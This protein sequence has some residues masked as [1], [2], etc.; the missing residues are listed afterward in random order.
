MAFGST[1]KKI[2]KVALPAAAGLGLTAI[3]GGAINPFTAKGLTGALSALGTLGGAAK[4]SATQAEAM[5]EEE[6]R[7]EEERKLRQQALIE[8]MQRGR[9]RRF[10]G[11]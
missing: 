8:A 6:R 11:M 7:K 2:G 10:T 4:A 3:S 5:E 9:P 1:L